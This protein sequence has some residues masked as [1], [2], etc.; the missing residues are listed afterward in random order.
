MCVVVS[1]ADMGRSVPW[2]AP[3]N[4]GEVEVVM[5]WCDCDTQIGKLLM[6]SCGVV[7]VG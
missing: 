7:T 6:S 4:T 1:V 2:K 3:V 5:E